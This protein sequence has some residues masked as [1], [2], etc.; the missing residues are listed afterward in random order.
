MQVPVPPEHNTP[1]VS[2]CNAISRPLVPPTVDPSLSPSTGED[3]DVGDDDFLDEAVEDIL[4]KVEVRKEG[5]HFF[6]CT[7]SS[8]N[9]GCPAH[10]EVVG[11]VL[12]RFGEA[13]RRSEIHADDAWCAARCTGK[14]FVV[15]GA[16]L[17]RKAAGIAPKYGR[18][19]TLIEVTSW[20]DGQMASAQVISGC[21][22][23]GNLL[24]V[25]GGHRGTPLPFFSTRFRKL[26]IS[27]QRRRRSSPRNCFADCI[28]GVA[29]SQFLLYLPAPF[30]KPL[31]V[32]IHVLPVDYTV[33]FTSRMI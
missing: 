7:M 17:V 1:V 28:W 12:G 4:R 9:I 15:G 10:V 18:C 32:Y 22:P 20:K 5:A 33:L 14:H 27:V 29:L 11:R 16:A 21:A 31:L 24:P 8:L 2:G 26:V 6:S 30:I 3:S 25:E 13:V 19:S 23:V